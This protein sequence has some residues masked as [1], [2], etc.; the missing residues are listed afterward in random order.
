MSSDLSTYLG[1]KIA[2]WL[3]G[4]AMPT[5]PTDIWIA[6]FDGNPKSGGTEV[7]TDVRA[8]GRV[9]AV[10]TVPASGVVNV[11]T[12]S[13][14]TDFG[15]SDGPTDITHVAAFDAA[16]SG[17][18]LASKPLGAPQSVILGTPVKFNTADLT[19]TIGSAT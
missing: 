18:L 15:T 4:V 6:L 11:L 5:A 3:G 8:A 7:T 12:S 9:A 17:N 2:R 1:N 16:S 19:F 13:T 10:W 14:D